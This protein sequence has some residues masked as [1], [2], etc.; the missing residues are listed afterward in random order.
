MKKLLL[1]AIAF[2]AVATSVAQ[3]MALQQ[4]EFF[5]NWSITL[6]G[7]GATPLANH[8]FWGDMRGVAGLEIRKQISPVFGMGVEGEWSVNTSSWLGY[9]N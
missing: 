8:A 6:K 7:G 2:M 9:S 3:E 1:S 5:D 4:S